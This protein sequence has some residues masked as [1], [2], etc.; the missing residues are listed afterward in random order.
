MVL[1]ALPVVGI[2]T[3]A[4]IVPG[5]LVYIRLVPA[6]T[7]ETVI[8][9]LKASVRLELYY[10]WGDRDSGE[11]LVIDGPYGRAAGKIGGVMDWAHWSRTS[12]YLT[13]DSKIVV[14]GTAYEDYIV[15]PSHLTI[16]YLTG[17]VASERWR[18]LG[19]FDGGPSLRFIP[20]SEQRECNAT[21]MHGE[22]PYSW[23]ARPQS[24]QEWCQG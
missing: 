17:Q 15:D 12:L 21:A 11:Y 23:A 9:E 16:K 14:L 3:V 8:P 20:V 7:A 13:E 19:A 1:L 18:Y 4:L 5:G 10:T 22:E 6:A 24:R 2:L